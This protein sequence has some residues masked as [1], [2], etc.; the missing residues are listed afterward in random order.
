M[1][2]FFYFLIFTLLLLL[3]TPLF[4]KNSF[5]ETALNL[6]IKKALDI[7]F[8]QNI[9]KAL[10]SSKLYFEPNSQSW[11]EGFCV[12]RKGNIYFV[13]TWLG[14]IK[15]FDKNGKFIKSYGKYGSFQQ[16]RNIIVDNNNNFYLIKRWKENPNKYIL[17]QFDS[18]FKFKKDLP[19]KAEKTSNWLL[20]VD[21]NNRLFVINQS[22]NEVNIYESDRSIKISRKLPVAKGVWDNKVFVNRKG[23]ITAH[24]RKETKEMI[25]QVDCYIKKNTDVVFLKRTDDMKV[26]PIVID[27]NMVFF[28]NN[29]KLLKIVDYNAH[30]ITEK[31][32]SFEPI[33]GARLVNGMDEN[34]YI[35]GLDLDESRK[36]ATRSLWRISIT[37]N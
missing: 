30:C 24:F 18:N 12:D 21:N 34:F 2:I 17:K 6:N 35:L 28:I 8:T 29:E 23:Q 33:S 19:F 7:E 25:N 27:N 32:L 14:Q 11:P 15:S 20:N 9:G 1:K 26:G 13:D 22:T 31:K 3:T 16:A 36:T 4:T 5:A 37:H 10:S